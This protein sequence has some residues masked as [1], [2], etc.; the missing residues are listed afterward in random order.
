MDMK[1]A[2]NLIGQHILPVELKIGRWLPEEVAREHTE[3]ISVAL[4]ELAQQGAVSVILEHEA[5]VGR[6]QALHSRQVSLD[7]AKMA[8]LAEALRAMM[9]WIGAPP[10]DSHSYDSVREDAWKQAQQALQSAPGV[11]WRGNTQLARVPGG[12]RVLVP[13]DPQGDPLGALEFER[14]YQTLILSPDGEEKEAT[15]E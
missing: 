15:D 5:E 4:E 12:V 6:L 11:A 9:G 7:I 3:D 8:A 10:T 13:E 14:M 1:R 2:R